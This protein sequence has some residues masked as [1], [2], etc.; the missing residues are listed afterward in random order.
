MK[1]D[2]GKRFLT[3]REEHQN[4]IRPVYRDLASQEGLAR[5]TESTK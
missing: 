5:H 4:N 3:Q 2:R 1:A